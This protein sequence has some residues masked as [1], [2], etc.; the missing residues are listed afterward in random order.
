MTKEF[1]NTRWVEKLQ[2]NVAFVY[3]QLLAEQSL[4]GCADDAT[5]DEQKSEKL[6]LITNSFRLNPDGWWQ[7]KTKD[8]KKKNV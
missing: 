3:M 8:E 5:K 4:E 2:K 7:S 1:S 6:P